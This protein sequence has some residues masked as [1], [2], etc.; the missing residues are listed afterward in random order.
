M[1]NPFFEDV[2]DIIVRLLFIFRYSYE[3]QSVLPVQK[4]GWLV[5]KEK[6]VETLPWKFEE[7]CGLHM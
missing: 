7:T 2:R 1:F 5:E 3:L 4:G 6:H